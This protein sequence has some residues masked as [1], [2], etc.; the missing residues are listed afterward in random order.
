MPINVKHKISVININ[1][2]PNE[3]ILF[4]SICYFEGQRPIVNN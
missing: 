3:G 1:R 2:D 4:I